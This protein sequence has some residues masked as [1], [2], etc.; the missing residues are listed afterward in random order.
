MN[1]SAEWHP[2]AQHRITGRGKAVEL[3]DGQ[4]LRDQ[5]R[6]ILDDITAGWY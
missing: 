4:Q 3:G 1:P 2:N 5:W 6:Q